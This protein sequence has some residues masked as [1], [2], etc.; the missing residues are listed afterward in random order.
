MFQQHQ[1]ESLSEAWTR[2][3][4]L[5]QKVPHQ[6]IDLWLKIQIF[7][8][9]V[10]PIIRRTIDQAASGK[11]RDK[12]DEESWALL[13][14]LTLYDNESW[15]VPRDFAKPVKRI[16]SKPQPRELEPSFEARMQE[17]MASHGKR[18]ERFEKAIF[19]QRDEINGRMVEMF[20][21]LKELTSSITPEKV[22]VR[23]E[24]RNP[25]TKNVNAISL[26]RIKSEKFEENN[27][28]IDK[29]ITEHG[30][31]S[32]EE[33]IRI[34]NKE[35]LGEERKTIEPPGLQPVSHY[36]KHKI[37]KELIKGI[38]ENQRFND[39]FLATRVTDNQEKDKI[40]AK[41][42]KNR[43]RIGRDREKSKSQS[44]QKSIPKKSKSKAESISKKC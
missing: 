21:L 4:D 23:E 41:T 5:L 22:L 42:D 30:K 25:I 37:N 15:N 8:D 11:L 10:N 19:K 20:G 34:T 35:P 40:E 13:E 14:D 36:L 39:S 26:C 18:I 31:C 27:E 29:N 16:Y 7:Y 28:V 1:G 24:I 9:H 2:F 43:A 32:I 3:K 12:N 44:Q 17:Y 38:I 33:P 6:G